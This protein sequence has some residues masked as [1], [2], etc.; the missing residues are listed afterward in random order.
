MKLAVAARGSADLWVLTVLT[1]GAFCTFAVINPVWVNRNLVQ[2]MVSQS[3][4]LALVAVPLTFSIISR[5]IDLS[6]GSVLALQGMVLGRV[7]ESS[8][9]TAAVLA[10]I[11][12][13]VVIGLFHGFLVAKLGLSAIMAT[14]ATF[15]WARGLTLAI[16]DST[17]DSRRRL[18]GRSRQQA[19]GG[20]HDRRT[21]RRHRLRRGPV[22]AQPHQGRPLH[23]GDRW[24]T[25]RGASFRD[26]HRPLHRRLVRGHGRR[27]RASPQR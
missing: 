6:V 23:R 26:R 4:A 12:V 5:N 22:A 15:I 21:A 17:A 13:G 9:L 25:G 2:T 27:C 14:L 20:L 18:V 11:G 10:A 8:S 24:R 3:A 1:V 16:N 7:S 19:V